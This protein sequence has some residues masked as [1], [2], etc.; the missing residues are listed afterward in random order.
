VKP[1]SF[2]DTI[3]LK[4]LKDFV[5]GFV[6]GIKVGFSMCIVYPPPQGFVKGIVKK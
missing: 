4:A 3:F 2:S 5:G 6:R 1:C